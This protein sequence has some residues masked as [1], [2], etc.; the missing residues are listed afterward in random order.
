MGKR[1]YEPF[2]D[3]KKFELQDFMFSLHN[4][5]NHKSK[6]NYHDYNGKKLD[7]TIFYI[8]LGILQALNN[9]LDTKKL[10]VNPWGIEFGYLIEKRSRNNEV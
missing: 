10:F 3:I 6:Y 4:L 9:I 5:I 2:I 8:S 7:E 1:N